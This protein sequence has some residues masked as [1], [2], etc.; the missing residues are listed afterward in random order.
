M[1]KW[2][3]NWNPVL[4]CAMI[5]IM[6][7]ACAGTGDVTSADV[8]NQAFE[9]LRNEIRAV[10]ADPARET[11]AI[12]LVGVLQKDFET[13]HST[14]ATRTIRLRE[15]NADYDTSRADFEAFLASI[16]AQARERR[17]NVTATHQALLAAMTAEER[18]Q[19]DKSR[20][21]A[22]NAAIKSMQSI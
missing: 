7:T 19:V 6:V 20:S 11:E 17:Q 4:W 2:L 22:I 21:R 15:L 18:S 1:V 9:D 12:R 16:E 3:G 8:E 14:I 10:V 13:L 5:A